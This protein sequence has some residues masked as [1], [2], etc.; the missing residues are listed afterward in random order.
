MTFPAAASMTP[1]GRVLA[2]AIVDATS[3]VVRTALKG[4]WEAAAA[5][6]DHRRFL[7]ERL[8]SD[9][10]WTDA[11]CLEALGRAVVE[12][13]QVLAEIR[14]V[15]RSARTRDTAVTAT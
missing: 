5:I 13:D 4:N 12:S 8:K 1:E 9:D 2:Q 7:L 11:A 15:A 6:A 10:R 3:R 14:N